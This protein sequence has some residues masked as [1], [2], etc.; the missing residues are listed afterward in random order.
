MAAGLG[1][2][3]AGG[4]AL[5]ELDGADGIGFAGVFR[6]FLARLPGRAD[7]A[8]EIDAGVE[9]ARQVDRLLAFADAKILAGHGG[10][11]FRHWTAG[12]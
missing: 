7:A 6:A 12:Q 4:I 10:D 3:E 1:V 9:L 8:D 11:P 2:F 5:V